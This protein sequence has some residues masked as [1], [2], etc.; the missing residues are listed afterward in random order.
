MQES[1][2]HVSRKEK[3]VLVTGGGRGIGS[4]VVETLAAA[5][6]DVAFSY[7]SAAST[8]E[9]LR[10]TLVQQFPSQTF[11][12][13]RAD[14]ANADEVEALAQEMANWPNLY[15]FVHNSGA[16]YDKL[17]A[18]IDQPRA[19]QV[20]QVNFW[21]MT[22]LAA[23]SL[24]PMMRSRAGR[25]VGI[26][27]IVARQGAQGNAS[28]AATKGA[29]ASYMKSLAVE[30]ARK[31]VTANVIAPGYVDTEM[32]AAY[33]GNR[34]LIEKQIPC[35]RFARPDEIA[36]L[37]RYLLSPEAAYITGAE[38]TIDGGLSASVGIKN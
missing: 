27:S 1:R 4:K 16:T 11:I 31:G 24:R 2:Q 17:A 34:E 33:E 5:G 32:L 13:L 10:T 37:V 30:V 35:G 6:Y 8:A 14:L 29:M 22:R 20:M 7:R 26:G 12:A 21:S 38:L 23:A 25:I 36:G 3:L 15:G 9:E 18:M 19:E 28:Y